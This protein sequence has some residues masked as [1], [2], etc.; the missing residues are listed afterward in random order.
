MFLL[1]AVGTRV[2]YRCS[3]QLTPSHKVLSQASLKVVIWS[4]A[5][6]TLRQQPQKS[7]NTSIYFFVIRWVIF[8]LTVC[9]PVSGQW[10]SFQRSS[11]SGGK[12]QVQ[13]CLSILYLFLAF[14]LSSYGTSGIQRAFRR[15]PN[16]VHISKL[17]EVP[18]GQMPYEWTP[19]VFEA[20]GFW[21][22]FGWWLQPCTYL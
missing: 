8:H 12:N 21:P 15:K 18:Y 10:I 3:K 13:T 4:E 11:G 19:K 1:I 9:T 6:E 7:V 20:G 17:R 2:L 16:L 5:W 22:D 14:L